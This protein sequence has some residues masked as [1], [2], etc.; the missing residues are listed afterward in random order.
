[1]T[2][3]SARSALKLCTVSL[4]IEALAAGMFSELRV[5]PS[6]SEF[7]SPTASAL[8]HELRSTARIDF[9]LSMARRIGPQ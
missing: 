4:G 2:L 5:Y 1:M 7:S 8:L 9:T 3:Q 6:V